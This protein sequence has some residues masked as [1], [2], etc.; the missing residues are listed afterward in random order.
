MSIS[1]S[2]SNASWDDLRLF[3]AAIEHR[4]FTEAAQALGVGQATMSRR[5]A[6]LEADVGHVLFDRSRQGLTPTFAAQQLLPWA[7]AMGSSMREAAAALAG[8]EEAPT[9]RVRLTCP[10]GVAVDFL[11]KMLKRLR[12]KYPALVVEVLADVRLR[13]LVAHEADLAIRST[14]PAA[15]PLLVRKLGEAPVGLFASADFVRRLPAKARL[16]Q[17]AIIDWSDEVAALAQAF[18][19]LPCPRAMVTNDFLTMCAAAEAGL[20][21]IVTTEAQA[22]LRGLVRVPVAFPQVPPSAFY[23]VTH[24]ALRR[25]PRVA[26]V[27]DALERLMAE[28]GLRA[29]GA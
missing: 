25:V 4:S 29:R 19:A 22:K 26:V 17:V 16:E 27:V 13:D 11:P 18:E 28:L 23:V 12:V 15:G 3:L 14:A 5:I 10:P 1:H 9:G 2:F 24:Q 6:A 21:A 8:L 7:L 20:G